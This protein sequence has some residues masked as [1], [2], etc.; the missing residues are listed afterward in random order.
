V[1]GDNINWLPKAAEVTVNSRFQKP[2]SYNNK[3]YS[4][5]F[6]FYNQK[7]SKILLTS[8][9]RAQEHHRLS[10]ISGKVINVFKELK[11]IRNEATF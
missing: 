7:L 5:P 3:R 8:R 9:N 6:Y 4:E 2:L 11:I 10:V 1:A